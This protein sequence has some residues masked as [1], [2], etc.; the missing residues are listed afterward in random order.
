VL[1]GWWSAYE[2]LL[3]YWAE[4]LVIGVLQLA[5]MA[6]VLVLRREYEMLFTIPFFTIHYGGFALGHGLILSTLFGPILGVPGADTAVAEPALLTVVEAPL[7]TL[8][9]PE[10]L[11][12]GLVLLAGSHLFSFVVNFLMGGEWRSVTPGRLMGEPY[13]RVIILHV[14][15]IF[16]AW[17]VV[18]LGAPVA[19]LA[20]LVVIKIAV[21]AVAHRRQH[22]GATPDRPAP[23]P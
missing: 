7:R 5:R 4:N 12:L 21:D 16:G 2:I 10:G 20:L 11:L 19:A 18:A 15:L 14:V 6:T 23:A 8:A 9:S 17:A 22:R 13:G 1:L 3:L